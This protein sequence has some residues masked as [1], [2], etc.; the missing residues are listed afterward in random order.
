MA[1][2]ILHGPNEFRG[3]IERI[4]ATQRKLIIQYKSG[5]KLEIEASGGSSG[6]FRKLHHEINGIG[7]AGLSDS[8]ATIDI[9]NEK[10]ELSA[11]RQKKTTT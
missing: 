1:I 9:N 8:N 11:R 10:V 3:N 6:E 7:L 2:T 5:A 4:T